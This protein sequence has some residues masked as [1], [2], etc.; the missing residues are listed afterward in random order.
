MA[1]ATATRTRGGARAGR[2][3]RGPAR[4]PEL[5]ATR[6]LALVAA[7]VVLAA[8]GPLPDWLAPRN[9]AL[10]LGGALPAAFAVVAGVAIAHQRAAHGGAGAR[11]W[12]GRVLR[13]VAALVAAGLALEVLLA[14]PTPVLGVLPVTGD[15][16]RLGVATGLGMV[17]VHLPGRTRDLLAT[18]LVV[19][20]GW[21]VLGVP[22]PPDAGGALAG[23]DARLLAGRATTPIDPDGLTAL[24]PTVALVLVG[25]AVG[26]WLRAQPRGAPTV[27]RLAAAAAIAGVAAAGLARLLPVLPAV[28]TAPVL[29]AGVGVVLASLALG[30]LATRRSWS[31]RW[32]AHLAVAGRTTLPLWIA[33]VLAVDWFG[34]TP[35]VRWLLREVL[36]PPLGDT[37]AVVGLGLL[38]GVGLV[39]AGGALTDRGWDLRA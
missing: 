7:A 19:A 3:R 5:D 4:S 39:R 28:W 30:Q 2:G 9:G 16:A 34:G 1:A 38:L 26:E 10:S 23:W 31:D 14:L 18:A 11:W 15:L 20:H 24:A 12:C 22:T 13:R 25:I 29:A 27:A 32:V 33:A 21:L 37:G 17:L 36:W 35:P 6:A 8:A